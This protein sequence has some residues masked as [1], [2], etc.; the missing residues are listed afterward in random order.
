MAR[1]TVKIGSA[2]DAKLYEELAAVARENGQSERSLL[3]SAIEHYLSNV[4][5][6]Q[7]TVR[8]EVMAA[9]RRSN[10]KFESCIESWRN[11]NWNA[12]TNDPYSRQT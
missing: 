7:H 9:H 1:R 11:E 12:F 5:P 6:S 2:I 4:F 3:E 10:K 8:P